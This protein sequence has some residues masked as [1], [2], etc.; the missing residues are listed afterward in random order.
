[1]LSSLF[2]DL[3][4][5]RISVGDAEALALEVKTLGNQAKREKSPE[6][7]EEVAGAALRWAA[8]ADPEA[9]A[10]ALLCYA[11]A[12]QQLSRGVDEARTLGLALT[13][14]GRLQKQLQALPSG[15]CSALLVLPSEAAEAADPQ[16]PVYVLEADRHWR[17][18]PCPRRFAWLIYGESRLALGKPAAPA[19]PA[20]EALQLTPLKLEDAD[21]MGG[22]ELAAEA[23][24]SGRGCFAHSDST[25]ALGLFAA[26]FICKYGFG[27]PDWDPSQP[28][29]SA[30]EAIELIQGLQGKDSITGQEEQ[31]MLFERGLWSELMLGRARKSCAAVVQTETAKG[32]KVVHQPGD[33]NCLF[34]S[35]AY[36]LG[37]EKA[38]SL[39]RRVCDFM[40]KNPQ[41]EISGSPLTEWIEMTSQ[42]SVDSYASKMRRGG[43][44]GGAP[45]IAVCARMAEIDVQV[46]E[47]GGEGFD[48]I[49]S[50][51]GNEQG[52][53]T[54]KVVRVLYTG[55]LH[56]VKNG[57]QIRTEE[58]GWPAQAQLAL[59]VSHLEADV[60]LL[61][62]RKEDL[63]H[64][65]EALA[66]AARRP[67]LEQK[68]KELK[69]EVAALRKQK[70]LELQNQALSASDLERRLA[71]SEEARAKL[72]EE[73]R[74]HTAEVQ[75]RAELESQQADIAKSFAELQTVVSQLL[76]VLTE[77]YEQRARLSEE[78]SAAEETANKLKSELQRQ[79]LLW[80]A[81][82][83]TDCDAAARMRGASP[84]R[85]PTRAS[86]LS[87][88][89]RAADVYG[90]DLHRR[91]SPCRLRCRADV[92]EAWKPKTPDLA[93]LESEL[94]RL[95]PGGGQRLSETHIRELLAVI[96]KTANGDSMPAQTC[97]ELEP[98]EP[99]AR[100]A[101]SPT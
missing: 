25:S 91:P 33:G 58:E 16:R 50:F 5:G 83:T 76:P 8:S 10:R 69:G 56:Y 88:T 36:G 73:C 101:T 48:L 62:Q 53:P 79:R 84:W 95:A 37:K 74:K 35:L 63:E 94:H 18:L 67:D 96:K 41:L 30:A 20:L 17:L 38:A 9:A 3:A 45:E 70:E 31:V 28:A 89:K 57:F 71:D 68:L 85:G 26:C 12:Q 59:K 54:P 82:G 47:P 99:V 49:A 4:L 72:E 39:R 23:L 7:Y 34:H 90:R 21:A 61:R 92:R 97:T 42:C 44:W 77:L 15:S 80:T 60:Q 87:A 6:L 78:K 98:R 19:D 2:E 81:P 100:P 29:H 43:E 52:T 24:K 14:D 46:Y 11:W 75:R 32:L 22:V 65:N 66:A 40:Q 1:M 13:R 27:F 51:P 55:R 93:E 64:E 86:S